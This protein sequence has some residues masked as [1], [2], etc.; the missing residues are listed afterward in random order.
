MVGVGDAGDVW[1]LP[2]IDSPRSVRLHSLA[3]NA[4]S[5]LFFFSI[6]RE[7]E[8]LFAKYLAGGLTRVDFGNQL[9]FGSWWANKGRKIKN[10]RSAYDRKEHHRDWTGVLDQRDQFLRLL[11]R[12]KEE[13]GGERMRERERERERGEREGERGSRREKDIY[14][15]KTAKDRTCTVYLPI[16]LTVAHF[17]HTLSPTVPVRLFCSLARSRLLS[18]GLP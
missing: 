10:R 9:T 3:A 13:K 7:N 12:L 18:S 17:H 14:I 16:G 1:A 5:F 2:D 15:Y 8:N 11:R 4:Y 6:A